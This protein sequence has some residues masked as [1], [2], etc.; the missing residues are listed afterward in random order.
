MRDVKVFK[1]FNLVDNNGN[2]L[3]LRLGCLKSRAGEVCISNADHGYR[4][5]FIGKKIP[6]PVRSGT[7][8]NG[9]PEDTMLDWLR[10]SGWAL[11]TCVWMGDGSAIAYE[12]PDSP[13]S[14]KGNDAAVANAGLHEFFKSTF[15]DVIKDLVKEQK[16]ITAVRVYRYAHGGSLQDATNAVREICG[17]IWY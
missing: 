7:W 12:L 6:M 10:E 15:D 5:S 13:E 9:F 11:H 14:S 1:V 2:K 17:S 3:Q 8:F 4:W 16:R